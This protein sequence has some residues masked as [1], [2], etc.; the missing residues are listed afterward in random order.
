MLESLCVLIHC[1]L[2]ESI[3]IELLSISL[4]CLLRILYA[5][6]ESRNVLNI[7]WLKMWSCLMSLVKFIAVNHE[8]L[9]AKSFCMIMTVSMIMF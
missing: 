5:L 3:S 7:D 2:G 8:A 4:D 9:I 6:K 1:N